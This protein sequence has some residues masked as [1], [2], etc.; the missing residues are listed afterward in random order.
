MTSLYFQTGRLTVTA[1]GFWFSAGGEKGSFGYY[2]HLKDAQGHP[3]YPDTQLRGD[4]RM[5]AGWLLH[6]DPQIG[7]ETLRLQVFGEEGN[8]ESACLACTDV[9]L[10]AASRKRW[11]PDR[12]HIKPTIHISSA[13]R[14]VTH[15]MLVAKEAAW[16]EGLTL[17]A[18]LYLGCTDRPDELAQ[19]QKLVD[20][21]VALLSGFGAQRSRGFGRGQIQVA[22][23][24]PRMI[25]SLADAAEAET[26]S[27]TDTAP[28]TSWY[29][30]LQALTNFRNKPVEPGNSPT[31]A[32]LTHIEAA[33]LR[34]WLVS[35]YQHLY[36]TW[37]TPEQMQNIQL[38]PLYPAL[39]QDAHR[40]PGLPPALS[41]MTI[42]DPVTN[43]KTWQDLTG[44]ER[45]EDQQSE[46][47]FRPKLAWVGHQAAVSA[48]GPPRIFFTPTE[49]RMRNSMDD[50]FTTVDNGLFMQE[51]V[52]AGTC[53][54]G[55]LILRNPQG[56]FGRRIQQMLRSARPVLRG[57]W[58]D[59]T[60]EPEHEP[61]IEPDSKP[62]T[63][64]AAPALLITPQPFDPATLAAG[65]DDQRLL[66]TT[67]T[68]FHAPLG[69]PRRN[70][71]CLAPGSIMATADH[72]RGRVPWSGF[73]QE[74][75][76]ITP[77]RPSPGVPPAPVL[78]PSLPENVEKLIR[79][80]V[81]TRAQ[82]GFFREL[83]HPHLDNAQIDRILEQRR[84][85]FK[86][87]EAHKQLAGIYQALQQQP[88]Y[89]AKQAFIQALLRALVE[90]LWQ[91][92]QKRRSRR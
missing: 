70:R 77:P 69:R 92:K 76:D 61:D 89:A 38:L 17:E 30:Y 41:S 5:A 83:Q 1:R 4:L 9:Q 31:L 62:G 14:T 18:R 54:G 22:W 87:K 19:M 90:P 85:K 47:F 52:P 79:K 80:G 35:T 2:P 82:A 6:L 46:N 39:V 37:P 58:F 72:A 40:I 67:R 63:A 45:R 11:T 7:D 56:T 10:D 28:V 43:S 55:R 73:G 91:D 74:L 20:G 84:D 25:A 13:T 57:T 86:G 15:N 12:F 36:G 78:P 49:H 60:L 65:S 23:E 3:F 21:A 44:V 51:L 68:R 50:T 81:L 24:A 8:S 26:E 42:K 27:P 88:D 53:F 71:I 64:S 48:T 75:T 16:L 32:T 33:Q 59:C 34:G 66:L 29:C